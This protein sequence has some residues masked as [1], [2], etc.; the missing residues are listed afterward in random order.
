MVGLNRVTAAVVGHHPPAAVV[1]AEFLPVHPAVLAAD[2]A[3]DPRPDTGAQV[4]DCRNN[5]HPRTDSMLV[6]AGT[7]IRSLRAPRSTGSAD[8]SALFILT[9]SDRN[10]EDIEIRNSDTIARWQA[11]G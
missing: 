6:G 7:P 11:L 3:D 2:P 1:A 5:W 9:L 4:A 10:G 8:V